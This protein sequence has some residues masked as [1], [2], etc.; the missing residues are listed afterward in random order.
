MAA[1]NGD[2]SFQ[3]PTSI[4]LGSGTS[5][6]A[7]ADF[8]GDGVPDLATA[9]DGASTSV[10]LGNGDRSFEEAVSFRT[11]STPYVIAAAD[12][13]GKGTPDLFGGAWESYTVLL[14]Q[15][16]PVAMPVPSLAFGGLLI[17]SAGMLL[18]GAWTGMRRTPP[19]QA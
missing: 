2:S 4:A 1:G 19:P 18:A 6:I 5:E 9:N 7:L 8:D 12:F 14:N 13:D 16:D 11:D 10:F 3:A 17:V 15:S